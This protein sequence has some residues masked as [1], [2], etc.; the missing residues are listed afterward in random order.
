M[1]RGRHGKVVIFEMLLVPYQHP[2][3]PEN[4]EQLY[5]WA[6]SPRPWLPLRPEFTGFFRFQMDLAGLR[7]E[8][9]L[10]VLILCRMNA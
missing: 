4:K 5:P 6:A 9:P 3:P 7:E 2:F 1:H 10:C 8:A